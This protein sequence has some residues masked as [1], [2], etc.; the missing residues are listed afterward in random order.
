VVTR[1]KATLYLGWLAG[2]VGLVL[3]GRAESVA[4]ALLAASGALLLVSARWGVVSEY[5][6]WRGAP[7]M[8]ASQ[9]RLVS[10]FLCFVAACFVGLGIAMIV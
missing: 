6:G 10:A 3:A 7:R 5:N 1:A 9:V 8:P 4:G 2:A